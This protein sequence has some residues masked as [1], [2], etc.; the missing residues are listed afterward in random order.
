MRAI[1]ISATTQQ[2]T[3]VQNADTTSVRSKKRSLGLK[4]IGKALWSLAT[5]DE[6]TSLKPNH[7][8]ELYREHNQKGIAPKADI[9]LPE[10]KN[11]PSV[12]LVH[13]GGFLIGSRKMKPIRFLASELHSAGY[14]V[15]AIDYRLIFRGGDLAKALE[16][17]LAALGW[18]EKQA[19]TYQL[20]AKRIHL[21]GMSA[22]ATLS[23]LAAA[24][25]QASFLQS[26][27][28]FF[29]LYD[30]A[31]LDGPLAACLKR[32]LV[33]DGDWIQE[34]PSKQPIAKLPTLLLHGDADTLVYCEQAKEFAAKRQS[35]NISTTLKV[36]AN[37]AHAFTNHRTAASEEALKDM[38]EF[39]GRGD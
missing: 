12:V 13:G 15:C 33:P 25:S 38:L 8:G 19:G 7:K 9:Y 14:A 24:K 31:S 37:Q 21:C 6:F 20:D 39:L 34:A 26:L 18:W 5:P 16:D 22:G 2:N 11:A 32:T 29:G 10:I 4:A 17:V 28:C 3:T 30:F 23:C 27:I 35:Q 36:F 1:D